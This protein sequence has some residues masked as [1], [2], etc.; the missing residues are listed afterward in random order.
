MN[1]ALVIVPT[2]NERSNVAEL[3]SAVRQCAPTT[4]LLFVDDNSPDGTGALLDEIADGNKGVHV[5]HKPGKQG[6]GRAYIDG[7]QWALARDYELIGEMD[8][9]FSHNPADIPR[10]QAA[11][12]AGADLALG[13]R[14]KGGVRVI[15]WPLN[16]LVLSRAATLYVR[17][18]TGLPVTDPTGGFKCSRRAVLAD[19][20]LDAIRSNGY[21]FQIEM[22]HQAWIRGF[23]IVEVPIVFDERRSGAS[24]MNGAIVREALW[25][26]WRLLW[27][28]GGRRRPPARCRGAS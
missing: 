23:R 10:L 16:R 12:A 14:Y 11:V 22:T 7:F 18:S 15:N 6:L 24:K 17:L 27:R 1:R 20:A 3:A 19:L 2:Y 26:T 13:S 9:D 21:S 4:E 5:L 28:N 25:M 8:A